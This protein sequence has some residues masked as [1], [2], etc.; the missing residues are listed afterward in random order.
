MPNDFH[1][2]DYDVRV[3]GG[4]EQAMIA[5]QLDFAIKH[6]ALRGDHAEVARRVVR[7]MVKALLRRKRLTEEQRQQIR[8]RWNG[9]VE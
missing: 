9:Y 5:E 2:Y 3:T 6:R 4:E 7:R 1:D 8:A